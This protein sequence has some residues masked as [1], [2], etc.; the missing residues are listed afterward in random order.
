MS[1]YRGIGLKLI[2]GSPVPFT[3]PLVSA[4]AIGQ[5]VPSVANVALWSFAAWLVAWFVCFKT[6]FG[7]YI[8]AI[9]G[10]ERSAR[11]R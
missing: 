5:A 7:L 2:N 10:S 8:Y 3:N 11:G 6:R 9:G 4:L 1:I